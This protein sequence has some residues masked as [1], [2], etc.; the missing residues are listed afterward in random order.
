MDFNMHF[1]KFLCYYYFQIEIN[2]FYFS[3]IDSSCMHEFDHQ[4]NVQLQT[5]SIFA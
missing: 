3:L 1:G 5:L 4:R 2:N